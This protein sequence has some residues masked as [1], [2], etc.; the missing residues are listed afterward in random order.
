ME[1]DINQ[2]NNIFKILMTTEGLTN[3]A[4][5]KFHSSVSIYIIC[6]QHIVS[7]YHYN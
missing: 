3:A 5:L 2:D 4:G 1:I 6:P 7:S